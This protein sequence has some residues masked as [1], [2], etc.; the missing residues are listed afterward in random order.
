MANRLPE[1]LNVP[2][3]PSRRSLRR[4][5]ASACA[6]FLR[7][8]II[9]TAERRYRRLDDTWVRRAFDFPDGVS[10]ETGLERQRELGMG[11]LGSDY[12]TPLRIPGNRS[13]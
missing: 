9:P 11:Q 10:W 7:V 4:E 2:E 8:V 12:D 5:T 6:G 13:L 3:Q 1:G